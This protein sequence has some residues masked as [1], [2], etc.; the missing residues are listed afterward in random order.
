[1]R[2]DSELQRRVVLG[3]DDSEHSERAFDC[4]YMVIN[5]KK[6]KKDLI[7]L[8]KEAFFTISLL[9]GLGRTQDFCTLE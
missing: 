7:P 2:P 1:M 5:Q 4:K 3:V 6:K 8:L 9:I